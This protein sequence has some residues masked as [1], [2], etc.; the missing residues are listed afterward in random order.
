M[1]KYILFSVTLIVVIVIAF[2]IFGNGDEVVRPGTGSAN[3]GTNGQISRGGDAGEID[4]TEA[5]DHIGEH[6]TVMGTVLKVFTSK[7]G[8]T[9]FDFCEDWRDCP[10]SAVIFASDLEKFT[11]VK[12]YEREVKIN[13]L[14]KSYN[15]KAEVIIS[16][17]KQ[18]E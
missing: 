16:D 5:P 6:A 1:K 4:Y 10:F 8:V 7:S 18:V 14:I 17:P 11:D 13:G 15:G 3:D 2:I 9:F 12:Q